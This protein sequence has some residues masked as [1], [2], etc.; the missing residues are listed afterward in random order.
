MSDKRQTDFDLLMEH[1]IDIRGRTIYL[2][3]EVDST[4]IHKFVRLLRYLDKTD[5]DMCIVLDSEGGDVNL[6]LAA[7]DAIKECRNAV[8]IKVVGVAMSMGSIILQAADTRVMT[9]HSR[10]MI[11]RGEMEVGGNF[12]DVK[13]A[14]QESDELDKICLSIYYDK[15]TDKDPQ[16]KMAQLQKMMDFDTYIS[17]DKALEIGL[18]DEIEGES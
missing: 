2:Q 4:N 8:E 12:T 14:V 11:H 1:G 15:I 7:Y 3:G 17:A 13:R 18:I 16:F 5:G 6:G 10:I 9:K